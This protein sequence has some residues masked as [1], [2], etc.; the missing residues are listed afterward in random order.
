MVKAFTFEVPPLVV[1]VTFTEP[2][3]AIIAAVTG[4]VTVVALLTVVVNEV[5]PHI[6]FAPEVKFVPVTLSVNAAPPAVAELGLSAVIVGAGG[7]M[8]NT[9]AAE[10]PPLV[11]TVTLTVPAEAIIA[12][13][14][15][16]VTVVALLTVVVNEAVPH[17]TVAPV[18]KFVPVT[19]SVNAAPPAVAE[20]GLSAV[21]VGAG[22]LMV[23][24]LA[25]EVP[26]LVVTVTF[27][28]PAV[29]IIAAVTGAV[30]VVVLLAVVVSEAVPH[31]TFAPE[32]KFVPVTVSVNAAPPAVA[33]L[34]LS[35]VTVGAG[36]L[37]VNT[38]A[39]EVPPLVVTVTF[40]EPAVAII[41][42]VTGAVTVV[43]LLTVV[44][45]EAV[46]HITFAPEIKLVPVTLSVNAAPPAV[47][48]LG[49]KPLIVG[50]AA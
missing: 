14:T 16:A 22:G 13:V 32:I 15:G 19:L 21:M 6:T 20:L 46:P 11:V 24:T 34:G 41:A 28:V 36:G 42:A 48:E 45:N 1:T 37:M 29:A 38:L 35:A 27:T 4:A 2:A 43:V 26:P 12:A 17:I 8:V 3:V 47:A 30:T 49:L 33:E 44:V 7:L 18:T 25:V 50:V 40:T 10:V 23:N 31:I 9:L 39:A 5:V